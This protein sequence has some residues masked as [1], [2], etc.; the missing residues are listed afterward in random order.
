[1]L[2]ELALAAACDLAR[3]I[4]AIGRITEAASEVIGSTAVD[5]R[6]MARRAVLRRIDTLL[7]GAP[8]P[9]CEHTDQ[10]TE[11]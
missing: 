4:N 6:T 1:M 8:C 10:E 11:Q 7:H 5:V 3:V 9:C 2:L